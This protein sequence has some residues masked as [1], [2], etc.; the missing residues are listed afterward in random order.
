MLYRKLHF[1]NKG[2]KNVNFR[3]LNQLNVFNVN[4]RAANST[5]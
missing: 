2:G 5:F 1:V 4:L 3:F